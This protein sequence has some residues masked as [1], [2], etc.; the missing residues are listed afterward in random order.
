MFAPQ[1]SV[2]SKETTKPHPSANVEERRS[3]SCSQGQHQRTCMVGPVGF[4]REHQHCVAL[5]HYSPGME[6]SRFA[7]WLANTCQYHNRLRQ[8]CYQTSNTNSIRPKQHSLLN[9]FLSE[10]LFHLCRPPVR[11]STTPDTGSTCFPPRVSILPPD[12]LTNGVMSLLTHSTAFKELPW[13]K[14]P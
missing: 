2:A 4:P 11:T 10:T 3:G 5:K 7:T 6:K 1:C 12:C 8:Q 14:L 13:P 9:Y